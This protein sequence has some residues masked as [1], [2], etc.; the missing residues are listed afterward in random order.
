MGWVGPEFDSR[1]PDHLVGYCLKLLKTNVKSRQFL[2]LIVLLIL[3][4][5][6]VVLW[7]PDANQTSTTGT[8]QEPTGAPY[9]TP[10]PG[11]P[12]ITQPTTP[13]PA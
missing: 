4:I 9:V 6:I 7:R 13:P 11:P 12:Q 3:F 5:A 8:F 10:P 1:H 2:L